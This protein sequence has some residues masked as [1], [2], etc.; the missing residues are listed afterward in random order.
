MARLP[1]IVA[2]SEASTTS[3][4]NSRMN[5][6]LIVPNCSISDESLNDVQ[7]SSG[8]LIVRVSPLSVTAMDWKVESRSR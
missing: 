4:R 3:P 8:M 7:N 1:S 2:P 5:V 6:E